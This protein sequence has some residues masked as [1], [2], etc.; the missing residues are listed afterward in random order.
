MNVKSVKQGSGPERRAT[1]RA[2]K[3]QEKPGCQLFSSSYCCYINHNALEKPEKTQ[4]TVG[5][6]TQEKRGH[7]FQKDTDDLR[8]FGTLAQ[9]LK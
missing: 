8:S 7:T 1:G 9:S 4:R 3:G 5:R 6:P 2:R